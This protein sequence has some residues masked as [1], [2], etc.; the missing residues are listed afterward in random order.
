[1]TDAI[2]PGA[3]GTSRGTGWNDTADMAMATPFT[4]F[5]H[6]HRDG[7]RDCRV[8]SMVELYNCPPSVLCSLRNFPANS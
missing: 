4:A 6:S 1:M 7:G 2:Q 3:G 5:A 8:G